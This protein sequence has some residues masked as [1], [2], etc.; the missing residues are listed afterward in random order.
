M[1]IEEAIKA[2]EGVGIDEVNLEKDVSITHIT[3]DSRDVKPNSLFV[4]VIGTTDDG[5]R[6]IDEAIKKGAKTIVYQR[7]DV[8][9]PE[10]ANR[11]LVRD[12]RRALASLASWFYGFP[13]KRLKL[14]GVTGTNGKSS[15]VFILEHLMR[16]MGINSGSLGTLGASWSGK[17]V[18]T[19]NTTPD[20]IFINSILNQMV[21][22]GVKYAFMEVSSHA[23]DQKRIHSL[24][25]HSVIFTKGGRD[26]IDYHKTIR[27]YK[28]TKKQFIINYGKK[29]FINL[30]D[31]WGRELREELEEAKK[32]YIGLS[33][34]SRSST[35]RIED[36]QLTE[37]GTR[38]LLTKDGSPLVRFTSN[39]IGRYNL[40]NILNAMAFAVEEGFDPE[41]VA[42]SISRVPCVPGR[43]ERIAKGVFLDYAHTPDALRGLL[44]SA[45]EITEGKLMVIFGCGGERDRGK[46]PEMGRI[47]EKLAD[48]VLVTSDNPR[49]EDPMMIIDEITAGMQKRVLSEEEMKKTRSGAFSNP[50]RRWM[51]EFALRIKGENDT[52]LVA[53]KGH[54][55]YMEL[56]TKR[57]E[58][59]DREAIL[60]KLQKVLGKRWRE[61]WR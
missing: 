31:P 12:S 13:S 6:Y 21:S 45:R 40:Y 16:E 51:I 35:Y 19:K 3:S 47:A 49:R 41:C 57:I 18:S 33:I 52:L 34:R 5:H 32:P 4:A 25:F 55:N 36:F 61:R 9:F 29:A 53:G 44:E 42:D 11:I 28:E 46:R 37:K 43:M 22:D 50:D 56:G 7:K 38:G 30:D 54:E 1:R 60:E 58:Y 10:S 17:S 39:L 20:P 27:N 26:H 2:L 24:E 23:I 14:I 59:S 15:T 48:I 8:T